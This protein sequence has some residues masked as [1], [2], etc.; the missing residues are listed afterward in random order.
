[1]P[2]LRL[3]NEKE[4]DWRPEDRTY[5]ADAEPLGID[6]APDQIVLTRPEDNRIAPFAYLAGIPIDDAPGVRWLYI[7]ESKDV[8]LSILVRPL[9]GTRTL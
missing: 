6:Q 3:I 4:F 2:T 9:T 7:N 8:F 1:M 5:Y